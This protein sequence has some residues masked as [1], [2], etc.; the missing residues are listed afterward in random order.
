MIARWGIRARVTLVAFV[1]MLV[2]AALMT[3][4]H[5][6]LRLSDLDQAL[7]ARAHAHARQLAA[8]S[9]YAIFAGDRETLG[10]L[11][12]ALMLED[13]VA[14]IAILGADGAVL[15]RAG[16]F[17]SP[18]PT[19]PSRAVPAQEL[20]TP[21]G[22]WLRIV[23]PIKPS[24][25]PAD[26]AFSGGAAQAE[27]MPKPLGQLVMDISLARLQQRRSEL[28]WIAAGWMVIVAV[29]SLLLARRMSRSVSGPIREVADAVLSIGRGQL[30]RRVRVTGGG[31]LSA[32]AEGV[33]EMA[34]RLEDAH[35]SMARRIDEATAE[36][37]ARKD[38]AERANLAKS[39]FLAAASHDLRQPLHALGLFLSELTQQ[40]LDARS[41]QITGRLVASTDAMEGLLDSLLDISRLDAG[42]LSPERTVFDMRAKLEHIVAAHTGAARARGLDLRLH[43]LP[44]WGLSDPLLFE[45]IITNLVSNA[46]RYTP[47]GRV[48]VACR[49]RGD[50]LRIEVRDSGQ[51]IAAGNQQIIFQEFVQLG[52][53]E[54]SRDKGL[55][56]GLA[57]VRR[58]A[59][60]LGH[61]LSLRSAPGQG[62]VFAIEVAAAAPP[63]PARGDREAV[64]LGH[65]DDLKVLLADD[66]ALALSAMSS[67]LASWGCEVTA[68]HSA[69]DLLEAL[70][71][72]G[73][74]DILIT[75]LRLGG[76]TDGLDLI[77]AV[78]AHPGLSALP[79]VLISGDTAPESLARI[80]SAGVQM[81]HKPVRPARL[82]ALMH[83]LLAAE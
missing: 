45:R 77:A 82:R 52:N 61:R 30:H 27:D 1:P 10:Q 20:T 66:D 23:E 75:D 31:S 6:G 47:Q 37:R 49:R 9:E 13:D 70:K 7:R 36:L 81:L 16:R 73:T 35:A 48:L 68:A 29:G 33:N 57:I 18:L 78:R 46:I 12:D 67:L 79:A 28:L 55:G 19:T 25:L 15:I 56:L 59:D 53:A 62:S 80:Q 8:A 65:F 21:E 14:A 51:G 22:R 43:C 42:V 44:C 83:R 58:L 39:R 74:P 50:L 4:T 76:S 5:T 63:E 2:V 26:D 40:P 17:V 34:E 54:R 72:C 11:A 24:H 71:H 41:R 60:L 38:E 3:A 64:S 69:T 32:L